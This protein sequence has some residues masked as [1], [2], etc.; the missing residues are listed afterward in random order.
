MHSFPI[1]IWFNFIAE[2][3]TSEEWKN[4]SGLVKRKWD[5]RYDTLV[6]TVFYY[7]SVSNVMMH[8]KV[9]I[10]FTIIYHSR[11]LTIILLKNEGKT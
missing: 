3:K 4:K 11:L 8:T 5:K 2:K 1:V 7:V 6:W 9:R 10:L